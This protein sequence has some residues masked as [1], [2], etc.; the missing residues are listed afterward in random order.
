MTLAWDV[1][2]FAIQDAVGWISEQHNERAI[3]HILDTL[4]SAL[5]GNIDP[6]ASILLNYT[7]DVEERGSYTILGNS[8]STTLLNAAFVNG[9]L[10]HA[11]DYDDSSWRLIGHPSAVVLPAVLAAAEKMDVSGPELLRAY[12]IGT[13]VSCKIG[14]AAEPELYQSGWHATS[15][16]GVIGATAGVGYLLG[17]NIDQ[18]TH[19]LGI[20]ASSASGLRQNFGSMT[21]PFHAGIAARNGANAAFL[22]KHGFTSNKEALDG[23]IG[24]FTTFSNKKAFMDE[25]LGEH[26]DILL[27]GFFIKPYPSCAATHTA[28]DNML[29]LL[30]AHAFQANQVESIY[31]GCGPVGPVMLVHNRPKTGAEGKFSMPFVLAAA[32]VDGEV[33]LDTFTEE[34][35]H[36]PVIQDLMNKVEFRID[37]QFESS[38]MEEAPSLIKV[39]MKDGRVLEKKREL[40]KGSPEYPLSREELIGKY[41]NCAS[42]VLSQERVERS[43]E[44][45]LSLDRL[46]NIS[47]LMRELK[48]G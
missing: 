5:A 30:R 46:Q 24:F 6:V 3:E 36:H 18:M 20:A 2:K 13:E 25:R 26:F 33:G 32:I 9:V 21:K 17:L 27:P 35:I 14:V 29:S 8:T 12:L 19:A 7:A 22:A 1:A 11:L 47:S 10:C 38:S 45:I 44:K 31:A 39:R 48:K 43:L 15:V 37:E 41:R 40:A 4:G 42:R 16:I 34:K 23:R 28:I